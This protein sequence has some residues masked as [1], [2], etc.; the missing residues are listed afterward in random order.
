MNEYDKKAGQLQSMTRNDERSSAQEYD[1][2]QVRQ[3]V[4]HGR[5]D[6]VLMV[7]YLSSV[8]EQLTSIR[9]LLFILVAL[10]TALL[11]WK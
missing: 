5:E 10:L 3:A 1:P 2:V 8:N 7:S 11:I 6:I 9:R 4:V